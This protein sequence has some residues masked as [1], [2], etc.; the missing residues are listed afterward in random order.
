[1]G[2]PV[3]HSASRRYS[4]ARVDIIGINVYSSLDLIHWKNAGR[5]PAAYLPVFT[6][7]YMQ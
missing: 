1:M 5:H 7:S 4:T 6:A 3:L 2:L